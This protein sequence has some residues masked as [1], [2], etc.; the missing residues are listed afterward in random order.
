V[1]RLTD[2]HLAAIDAGVTRGRLLTIASGM[3]VRE[4]LKWPTSSPTFAALG[5]HAFDSFLV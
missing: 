3:H 2:E 4:P 5:M 1:V